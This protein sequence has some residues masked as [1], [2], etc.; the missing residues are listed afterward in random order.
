MN[1]AEFLALSCKPCPVSIPELGDIYFRV[2]SVQEREDFSRWF[3]SNKM[4]LAETNARVCLLSVCDE[5][6]VP[7]FAKEDLPAITRLPGK[8][9]DLVVKEALACNKLNP[10]SMAEAEKN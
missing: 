8:V 10:E 2:W 4:K 6:G 1:K 3:D 9:I 5:T 7:L